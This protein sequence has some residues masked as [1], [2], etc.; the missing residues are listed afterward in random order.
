M[1]TQRELKVLELVCLGLTN[2]EIASKLYISNHTVKAHV[3]SILKK[4]EVKNRTS[5]AYLAAKNEIIN[6]P[7]MNNVI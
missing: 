2:P 6:I 7:I 3:A 5:A 1:F 4:F